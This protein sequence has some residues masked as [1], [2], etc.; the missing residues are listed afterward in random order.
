MKRARVMAV[1]KVRECLSGWMEL[2]AAV[3]AISE[4]NYTENRDQMKEVARGVDE[5][6]V[7]RLISAVA[8]AR[9]ELG[10]QCDAI[11]RDLC[12]SIPGGASLARKLTTFC[13]E[14]DVEVLEAMDEDDVR[15]L[16]RVLATRPEGGQ[17]RVPWRRVPGLAWRRGWVSGAEVVAAPRGLLERL[18]VH[19]GLHDRVRNLGLG[20]VPR[21]PAEMVVEDASLLEVATAWGS[22]EV[23]RY[24]LTGCNVEPR[25]EELIVAVAEGD[26][27]MAQTLAQRQRLEEEEA[28]GV[29]EVA[30][31]A[32]RPELLRWLIERASFPRAALKRV[33]RLALATLS[34]G[35]LVALLEVVGCVP[36]RLLR[37]MWSSGLTPVLQ[38]LGPGR[39]EWVRAWSACEGWGAGR[40]ALL[41][42]RPGGLADDVVDAAAAIGAGHNSG[43]VVWAALLCRGVR[44]REGVVGSGGLVDDGAG[45]FEGESGSGGEGTESVPSVAEILRG[46][47]LGSR[48]SVVRR[49]RGGL[50]GWGGGL[51]CSSGEGVVEPFEGAASTRPPCSDAEG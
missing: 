3:L 39:G 15:A 45:G 2:Q 41:R 24:L 33:A 7:F 11:L 20:N 43:E 22:R 28:K 37:A 32:M 17:L 9:P 4:E 29:L 30:V 26:A 27:W 48:S 50:L 23:V 1:G 40:R 10:S 36:R 44:R 16:R 38:S 5:E 14:E 6:D 12:T 8:D 47:R 35:C 31:R 21:A 34:L 46:G 42:V 51:G 49:S 18:R 25:V 13:A 19:V